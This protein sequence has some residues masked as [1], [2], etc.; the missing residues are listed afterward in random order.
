MEDSSLWLIYDCRLSIYEAPPLWRLMNMLFNVRNGVLGHRDVKNEGTSGDVYE[1]TGDGTKCIPIN[2]AFCTKMHP[3]R[4]NL[5]KSVELCGRKCTGY[6]IIRGEVASLEPTLS[7]CQGSRGGTG[8]PP[9]TVM[10]RMAMPQGSAHA[11]VA[12]TLRS[13]FSASSRRADLKV[14]AT[15]HRGS[16]LY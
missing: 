15:K 14:G 7:G 16:L 12:S 9:V 4:E 11:D 6:A 1:N 2:P 10:A 8:V 3:L 5:Q 13:A